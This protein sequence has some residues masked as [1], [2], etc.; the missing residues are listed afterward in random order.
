MPTTV[1][2]CAIAD[3]DLQML[4]GK[5]NLT[6]DQKAKLKPIL[7]DPSAIISAAFSLMS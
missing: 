4:S 1:L 2:V 7:Q 5:P 6:D 3:Q